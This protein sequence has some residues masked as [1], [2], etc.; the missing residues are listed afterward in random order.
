L[1]HQLLQRE[2][3]L[4]GTSCVIK[5]NSQLALISH[6]PACS[7][8]TLSFLLI[9]LELKKHEAIFLPLKGVEHKNFKRKL[10][11]EKDMFISTE[12]CFPSQA[13]LDCTAARVKSYKQ[14]IADH[15]V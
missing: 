12:E 15:N 2:A 3:A 10:K 11:S 4:T 6:H 1:R 5:Q 8:K 7:S 9:D 14:Q 13:T